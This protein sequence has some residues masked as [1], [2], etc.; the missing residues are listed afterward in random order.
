MSKSIERNSDTP[1]SKMPVFLRLPK[2][3]TRC[4]HTG[5]SRTTLCELT[6]PSELNNF[7]PPV[8][9]YVQ[10]TRADAKRGIRFID[11]S[12]LIAHIRSLPAGGVN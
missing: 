6:V 10:K 8:K 11:S 3:K 9:S 12:S 7:A 5:M 2:P 1:E 4:E